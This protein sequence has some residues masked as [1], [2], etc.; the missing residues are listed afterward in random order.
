MST[1]SSTVSMSSDGI[2]FHSSPITVPP[3]QSFQPSSSVTQ[4]TAT[5]SSVTPTGATKTKENYVTTN[6][7]TSSTILS[8]WKSLTSVPPTNSSILSS[9]SS[10]PST[11]QAGSTLG[12]SESDTTEA[13]TTNEEEIMSEIIGLIIAVTIFVFAIIATA[14]FII[15]K[16]IKRKQKGKFYV[17]SNAE[18]EGCNISDT[19]RY[20]STKGN[21]CPENFY[22]VPSSEKFSR[23]PSEAST[24]PM[25]PTN[26]LSRIYDQ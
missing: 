19:N 4:S 22:F 15:K 3:T 14:V 17:T 21:F 1:P 10:T 5:R 12:E 8:T 11:S 9:K 18:N 20:I 13:P 7:V 24:R 16:W 2:S 25:P 6:D 26:D 23:P